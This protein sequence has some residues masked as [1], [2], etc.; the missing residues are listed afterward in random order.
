MRMLV[1]G[2]PVKETPAAPP[3]VP[4]ERP[5]YK[6]KFIPPELS[7]WDYFVAKPFLP[8]SDSGALYDSDESG[9]SDNDEDDDDAFLS[10]T[11]MTEHSDPNSYSWSLIRLV[12]VKLAL[13]N[14]KT[15]LPLTGLDF[16]EL[17]VRSPLTN[18]VLKTLENWE[19]I[20]VEKMN[21]FDGPPPNYINTFPTDLSAGGGPAIL[22]HKAMLEPE[23]TPFKSKH[24]LSFPARRLWHFLVKQEMLQE[25]LIRYIFTKKRKQSESLD[26]HVEHLIQNCVTGSRKTKKV[27][28]D[29]GYPGGKA[30]IV[31]KESDIIMAFAINRANTNEIVLASTH[32][33]QEVDVS[34]LLAAQSYTWIGEEFDKESRSSDDVDYRSSHTNI[35]Q[36][37]TGPFAPQQMAASSSMPWLGSGQTILGA[38]VIMKR[39]L[40]NVKRMTSHPI[41]QYYMTGAQDGSVRMFEWNRPQQLICFRQAG[42]ARVTRLYFNSQGNK[43]GVADGEGFLSL[44][45]VNQTSSNPK[46]YLSWQCHG[47]SCGD[48]AFITSSSLIATAGQSNDGRNVCLWDTLVSPNNS[49]IHAFPCHE[50]GATVLQY[51]PKQ[52]LIITGGRKGFVCIFDIRQ[53]QLL[54]TFQAHDSTIKALALDSTEDFFV[55]GSAEGNMKVWKLAGHGLMHTFSAEHAKQSIFRN[56]GAG[57][58]KIETCPGNRIFTCGADGTLKMRVLPDRYNIPASIFQIL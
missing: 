56:I 1:P 28:A 27:E 43:C 23:N 26:N 58:M 40:N 30:K 3:P 50:N 55:T 34:T 45:Q 48:F 4:V 39:N 21:K 37:S 44:W 11:Q 36:A 51:A 33:V 13:H 25:T 29:M 52:Q 2:R 14:V 53:R 47:K 7:M 54:H 12:M 31:H 38:S 17:P 32:D 46:P 42:N 19:Q 6:E 49:M 9:A 22:R 35:A 15:F 18:A 24:H 20:L 16:I 57:V 5:T 8:L 41:Y 10:D